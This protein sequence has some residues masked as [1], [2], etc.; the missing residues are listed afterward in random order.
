[1][2]NW[3]DFQGGGAQGPSGD[4]QDGPPETRYLG[5]TATQ[6]NVAVFAVIGAIALAVGLV[7]FGGAGAV[8]DLFGGDNEVSSES[9]ANVGTA[10]PSAASA[11]STPTVAPTPAGDVDQDSGAAVDEVLNTFDPFSLMGALGS[12]GSVP[13]VDITGPG[14]AP[15]VPSD[16]VDDSLKAILIR[17]GDLPPGFQSLG[18]MAFSVP[19][20]VGAADMVASMFASGDLSGGDL[21]AMV[22]SAVITGPGVAAELGDFDQL[23]QV[24]QADLDEAAAALEGFGLVISEMEVL[25]A[26]GLGDAG[27]GMHMVMDFSGMYDSLGL[28]PDESMPAG[29]A[30][31]MY[32]FA[33]GDRMLM[34]MV[35]WPSDGAAGAD[36]RTLA[37]I[38]DGR[39]AGS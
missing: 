16:Q 10:T 9:V 28:P 29:I 37:D 35:M 6:F 19:T 2:G 27:V 4:K 33:R 32:I 14:G 20:D 38:M 17:Q 8:Q 24:T 7:F 3:N 25:D 15:S 5:L 23:G 26:S 30:W 22:M 34:V 11:P 36:A 31:D 39:A 13:N 21:G 12:A 1:M 18:E